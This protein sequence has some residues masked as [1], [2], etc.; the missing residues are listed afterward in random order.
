[1]ASKFRVNPTVLG[2]AILTEC[3]HIDEGWDYQQ[4]LDFAG[5]F[6]EYRGQ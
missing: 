5:N 3:L 6:F 2:L 1:M 4:A